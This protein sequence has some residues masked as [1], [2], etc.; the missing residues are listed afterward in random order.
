MHRK[1]RALL[2]QMRDLPRLAESR[3]AA[4]RL[5]WTVATGPFKRRLLSSAAEPAPLRL[6]YRDRVFEIAVTEGSDLEVLHEVFVQGEYVVELPFKP[7]IILDLGANIGATVAYFKCMY[8]ESQIWAFEPDPRAFHR[9][10]R[11]SAGFSGVHLQHAAIIG[12]DVPTATLHAAR[13]TWES[14][15]TVSLADAEPVVVQ[16]RTLT[17]VVCELALPRIDILKIDV[18]GA[19]WEI[20]VEGAALLDNVGAVAGEFHAD[21]APATPRQFFGLLEAFELRV[22]QDGAR[23]R[24]HA[25]RRDVCGSRSDQLGEPLWR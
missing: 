1:L 7:R 3:S 10:E 20:L 17:S 13:H 19:E 14:S 2:R 11:N 18:E 24:F 22:R 5:F 15:T 25:V 23:H 16:A 6:R 9:L 8:P 4:L 21:L 12:E